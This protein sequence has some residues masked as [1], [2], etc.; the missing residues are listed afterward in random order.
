[1]AMRI[2]G[3]LVVSAALTLGTAGAA[4][5]A[6]ASAPNPNSQAGHSGNCIAYYSAGVTANGLAGGETLGVGNNV[7]GND[8][9]SHGQRG[10][11]IK[12]LQASCGAQAG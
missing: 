10:D 9:T 8:N 6:P 11:E 1:M 4:L 2:L 3:A 12:A 5:A 7:S